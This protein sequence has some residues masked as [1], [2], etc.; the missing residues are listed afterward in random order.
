MHCLDQGCSRAAGGF[1]FP[2]RAI[3]DA[4]HDAN[5][6]RTLVKV[7]GLA[8]I[9]RQALRRVETTQTMDAEMNK[10]VALQQRYYA[11]TAGQYDALRQGEDEAGFD[12]SFDFMMSSLSRLGIRSILDVGSGTGRT[13]LQIRQQRPDVRVAGIE[14]VAEL[15]AV[16]HQKGLTS[17]ELVGGDATN[18]NYADGEF[19]LVCEF[20][21]LHHMPQPHLAVREMLRVARVAVFIC[22]VNNFGQGSLPSRTV[23]QVLNLL[24]L[25]KLADYI[26]TRGK[27]YL[28]SEGDGVYFSY[29]MFNDMA[30]IRSACRKVH[31]LDN[32]GGARADL[33]RTAQGLALLGIKK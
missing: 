8:A 18:L 2:N 13:L 21:A 27:G 15:R 29:S 6:S 28:V 32:T 33:Y 9:A 11:S 7:T 20:G 25:W 14:P 19:D 23:K 5:L 12:L 26:K 16:G 17:S 3:N 22:D 4:G 31:L 30:Q 10:A 1:Y 24:G